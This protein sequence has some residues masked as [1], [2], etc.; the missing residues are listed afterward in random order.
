VCG[1]VCVCVCVQVT[2]RN[3]AI[4]LQNQKTVLENITSHQGDIHI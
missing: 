1:C 3:V 4:R 2:L